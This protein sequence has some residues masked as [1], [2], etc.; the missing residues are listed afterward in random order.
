MGETPVPAQQQEAGQ[1]ARVSPPHVDARG[2][3]HSLGSPPQGSPPP[4]RLSRRCTLPVPDRA[5]FAM[6]R[7]A[8][9]VRRGPVTLAWVGD[10]GSGP[11]PG[12]GQTNVAFAITRKVGGAVVRNRIRRRL[13]AATRQLGPRLAPGAYLISAGAEAASAPYD[14]LVACLDTAAVAAR[15]APRTT[16]SSPPPTP[17]AGRPG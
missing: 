8:R 2:E 12:H 17:A 7:T 16:S 14:V 3:S 9:R 11:S 4:V 13:R 5:T 10:A 1:A 6:L 15:S